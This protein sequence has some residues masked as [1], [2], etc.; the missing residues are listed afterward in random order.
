M[1]KEVV[2]RAFEHLASDPY[3]FDQEA[4]IKLVLLLQD[5]DDIFYP[6]ILGISL[7]VHK[8]QRV[9]RYL[10]FLSLELMF[11]LKVRGSLMT[12]VVG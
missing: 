6:A 12:Y 1:L 4:S 3:L 5:L 9:I 7:E 2:G 10:C 11:S 8:V